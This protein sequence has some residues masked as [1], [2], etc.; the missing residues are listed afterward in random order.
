MEWLDPDWIY[1]P[2]TDSFQWRLERR[3]RPRLSLEVARVGPSAWRLFRNH[4]Y[5]SGH[6]NC[7]AICF[8]AFLDCRPVAFSAW[9]PFVGR[10][11]GTAGPA[12]PSHRL[13]S[14]LSGSGHRPGCGRLLRSLWAG[15]GYR[16]FT[17]RDIRAKLPPRTARPNWRLLAPRTV[18]RGGEGRIKNL[19]R[20]RA[21]NRFTASFEYVGPKLNPHI[22]AVRR[23]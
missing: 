9:L 3:G 4:H 23:A 15:L 17:P 6:L 11:R 1:E 21:T 20:S 10:L 19:A 18:R 14:R 8:C 5:L 12:E 7:T 13:P 22:A 2:G 16:A